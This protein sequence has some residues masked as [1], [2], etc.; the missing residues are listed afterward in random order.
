MSMF[1]VYNKKKILYLKNGEISWKP[2][3]LGTSLIL[4]FVVP[5]GKANNQVLLPQDRLQVSEDGL[6]GPPHI[7][8]FRVWQLWFLDCDPLSEW[9]SIRLQSYNMVYQSEFILQVMKLARQ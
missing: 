1:N 6:F 4:T 7:A 5:K 2:S 3:L 9:L 8:F